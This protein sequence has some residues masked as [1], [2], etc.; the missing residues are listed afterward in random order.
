MEK[1]VFTIAT[2]SLRIT[3]TRQCTTYV[4]GEKFKIIYTLYLYAYIH[5]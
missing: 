1:G 5:L 4:K 2:K 3:L